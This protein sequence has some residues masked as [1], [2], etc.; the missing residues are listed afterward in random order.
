MLSNDAAR[1]C[2]QTNA[3]ATFNVLVS[4][5]RHACA[6]LVSRTPVSR[7]DASLYLPNADLLVTEQDRQV[8]KA[9]ADDVLPEDRDR[10]LTDGLG[11]GYQA[12]STAGGPATASRPG[13]SVDIGKRTFTVPSSASTS[14]VDTIKE[15]MKRTDA[16]S[17]ALSTRYGYPGAMPVDQSPVRPSFNAGTG[18]EGAGRSMGVTV[19]KQTTQDD[20]LGSIGSRNQRK[21]GL[22]PV[23]R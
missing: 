19:G 22:K 12:A 11:L 23:K 10:L 13:A 4:Q 17:I 9:L 18:A 2:L 14:Q 8:M 7:D 16:E 5:E 15:G 20:L 21:S 3:I 6:A 1:T